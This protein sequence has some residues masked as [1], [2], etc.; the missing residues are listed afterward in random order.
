MTTQVKRIDQTE[1]AK[2]IRGVLKENFPTTKFSVRTHKYSG[3][4]SIRVNYTDGP[5]K[6]KVDHLISH[7][8][9]ASFDG[10]I[11]L[12]SYHNSEYNGELVRFA[13]DY[14]FIERDYS[15]ANVEKTIIDWNKTASPEWQLKFINGWA[16]GNY[17]AEREFFYKLTQIDF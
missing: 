10:M 5:A 6:S 3:G 8:E 13:N 1:V 2:I 11:D 17:D 9:G 4:S 14:L 16:L 7:F 15:P 12:K